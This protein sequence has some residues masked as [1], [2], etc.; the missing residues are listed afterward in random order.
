MDKDINVYVN[1]TM[2]YIKTENS[3]GARYNF[4]D[5]AYN[6]IEGRKRRLV[7]AFSNYVRNYYGNN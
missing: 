5:V 4:G 6:D 7:E 1:P 2:I 3:S